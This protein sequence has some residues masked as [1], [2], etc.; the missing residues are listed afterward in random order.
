[1]DKIIK[2]LLPSVLVFACGNLLSAQGGYSVQGTVVDKVG[3]VIGAAVVEIG[4]SNGTSSGMDGS[5]SLTVTGPSAM[6]EISCIGYASQTYEAASVPSTVTL[7]EDS[8]YIDEIV[9]IGYGVV[10]GR[11]HNDSYFHIFNDITLFP[12]Q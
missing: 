1:M 2:F 4:T 11:A 7:K 9:V 5:F 3:P 8:E 10:A 12:L 6:V